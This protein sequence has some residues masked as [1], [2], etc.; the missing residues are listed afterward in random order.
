MDQRP[1]YTFF[2]IQ[3]NG[4]RQTRAVSYENLYV[5]SQ[6]SHRLLAAAR[7]VPHQDLLFA[8]YLALKKSHHRTSNNPLLGAD[9]SPQLHAQ[10]LVDQSVAIAVLPLDLATCLRS[11]ELPAIHAD[12]C[13]RMI[14]ATAETRTM[15]VVTADPVFRCYGIEVLS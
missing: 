8:T 12:P 10:A 11:T 2:F 14:I 3:P 15:P 13:D 4:T 5:F 1:S 9:T 7:V 6:G